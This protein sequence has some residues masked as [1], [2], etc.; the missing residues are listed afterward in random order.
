MQA[1]VLERVL[2]LTGGIELFVFIARS[3]AGRKVIALDCI[4]R[5]EARARMRI[6]SASVACAFCGGFYRASLERSD[7]AWRNSCRKTAESMPSFCA[8][9]WPV[10]RAQCGWG[11][12]GCAAEDNSRPSSLPSPLRTGNCATGALDQI[13]EI[14]LRMPQGL[15]VS[16][17]ALAANVEIGIEALL[18]REHFDLKFFLDQQAQSALRGFGSRR[19]GIEIDHD[20]LAEASEQLGL[21]LG[22]GR[23]GAGDDVVKSGSVDGDAIHLAFD[24]DRVIQLA[25]RFFGLVK[26]EEHAAL[27]IDAASPANS[28]ISVQTFRRSPEFVR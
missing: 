21:D 20:I 27:G 8:I 18:E 2:R 9:S 11:R 13:I 7:A 28:N 5:T 3:V 6:L 15:A 14:F 26:I 1:F 4:W 23:A 22:K 19:I 24:Q 16:V 17:F 25:N 12:A 10:R